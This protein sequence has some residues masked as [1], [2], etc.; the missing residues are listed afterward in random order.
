LASEER[1]LNLGT[2][3]LYFVGQPAVPPVVQTF[4]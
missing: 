1:I 2:F 3:E 4:K